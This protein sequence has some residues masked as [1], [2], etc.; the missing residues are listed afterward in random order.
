M[1]GRERNNKNEESQ[2]FFLCKSLPVPYNFPECPGYIR[3]FSIAASVPFF[4]TV[5]SPMPVG[6]R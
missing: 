4:L 6:P 2:V 1:E 3:F 5:L